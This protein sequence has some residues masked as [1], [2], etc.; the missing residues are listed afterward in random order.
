MMVIGMPEEYQPGVG[1][2]SM[3]ERTAELGG[4][5]TVQSAPGQ[6]T[7]ICVWLPLF[8]GKRELKNVE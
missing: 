5:M 1:L 7:Q 8:S 3:R 2:R 6:G 4:R